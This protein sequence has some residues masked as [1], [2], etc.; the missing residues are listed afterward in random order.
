M[1]Q[2]GW[3]GKGTSL[4]RNKGGKWHEPDVAPY[5]NDYP[6]LGI[7]L[8]PLPGDSWRSFVRNEEVGEFETR[9]KAPVGT[10]YLKLP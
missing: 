6:I 2:G 3:P 7:P 9:K 10:S 8:C 5:E 4:E 1:E